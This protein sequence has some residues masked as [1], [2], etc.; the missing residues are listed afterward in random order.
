[1]RSL[2]DTRELVCIERVVEPLSTWASLD[3]GLC[4]HYSSRLSLQ[5]GFGSG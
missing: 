2:N 5:G 1:V 3:F 4:I